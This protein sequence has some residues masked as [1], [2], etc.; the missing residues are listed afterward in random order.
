MLKA[1]CSLRKSL[2]Y[3]IRM[4]ITDGRVNKPFKYILQISCRPL[5]NTALK[6]QS[7]NY[8]GAE[9]RVS[10][11]SFRLK[12][13]CVDHQVMVKNMDHSLLQFYRQA[14]NVSIFLTIID[15]K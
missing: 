6:S 14:N 13:I 11:F 5:I 7:V 3:K 9:Q 2:F 8:Q 12:M 10:S 15:K 4:K 1:L